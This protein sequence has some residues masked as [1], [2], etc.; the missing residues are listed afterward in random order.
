MQVRGLEFLAFSSAH[1]EGLIYY[2]EKAGDRQRVRVHL[3]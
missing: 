3:S 1:E 2:E